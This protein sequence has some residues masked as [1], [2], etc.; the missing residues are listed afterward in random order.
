MIRTMEKFATHFRL[1]PESAYNMF[2]FYYAPAACLPAC[3]ERLLERNPHLRRPMAVG[4]WD[5]EEWFNAE[6]ER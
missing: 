1:T 3:V 4:D 2:G 5:P 6:V